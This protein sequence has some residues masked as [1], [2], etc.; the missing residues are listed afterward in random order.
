MCAVRALYSK[1]LVLAPRKRHVAELLNFDRNAARQISTGI[2]DDKAMSEMGTSGIT[3]KLGIISKVLMGFSAIFLFLMMAFTFSDVIGRYFFNSPITGATE[4]ISFLLGLTVFSAFPLVTLNR[5]HITVGLLE[6]FF[7]GRIRYLQRLLVLLVTI[8][9][10]VFVAWLMFDQA[11]GMYED[12]TLTEYLDLPEA[13][14]VF[15]FATL[16]ALAAIIFLSV[17]WGYLRRGG[18]PEE[19]SKSDSSG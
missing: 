11:L 8:A 3:T 5:S 1:S 19:A 7:H 16:T 18:D 12:G 9:V 14:I 6:Q 15:V 2:G 4:I 17:I 13:P 10:V